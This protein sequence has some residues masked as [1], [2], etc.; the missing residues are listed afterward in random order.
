MVAIEAD[1]ASCPPRILNQARSCRVGHFQATE[2]E[3]PYC[4]ALLNLL[5]ATRDA[6]CSPARSCTLPSKRLLNVMLLYDKSSF[7]QEVSIQVPGVL[8]AMPLI[9]A[10]V[11]TRVRRRAI[12]RRLRGCASCLDPITTS[13]RRKYQPEFR[14]GHIMAFFCSRHTPVAL[15]Y[16]GD[17]RQ[18]PVPKA[19]AEY[20]KS[21]L[22]P[23]CDPAHPQARR[24]LASILSRKEGKTA[25]SIET[26]AD[27]DRHRVSMLFCAPVLQSLCFC[28]VSIS[29]QL[30]VPRVMQTGKFLCLSL[31]PS[32]TGPGHSRQWSLVN[33]SLGYA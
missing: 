8:R 19:T 7:H 17:Q 13:L 2:A 3:A 31:F 30:R 11:S 4:A 10:L 26:D 23:A 25:S 9:C 6:T 15:Q 24:S 22:S 14:L 18:A 21:T 1:A 12:Q 5:C 28:Y 20:P 29:Y 27:L 33:Q 16:V 32:G